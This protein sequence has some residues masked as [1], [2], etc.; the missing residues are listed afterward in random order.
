[1]TEPSREQR[2]SDARTSSIETIF[3]N[4]RNPNVVEKP[5]ALS[6]QHSTGSCQGALPYRRA[7]TRRAQKSEL[8]ALIARVCPLFG[9][10]ILDVAMRY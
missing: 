1:M 7:K 4:L 10:V 9:E 2:H 8:R 6:I 3:L 5:R